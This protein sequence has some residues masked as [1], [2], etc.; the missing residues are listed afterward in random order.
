MSVLKNKTKKNFRKIKKAKHLTYK[1]F[2]KLRKHKKRFRTTYKHG[3]KKR[4]NATIKLH[5][6]AE[7]LNEIVNRVRRKIL[8][9]MEEKIGGNNAN[10]HCTIKEWFD[11]LNFN[12]GKKK[13]N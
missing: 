6:N 1:N 8:K 13:L 3:G 2:K 11:A 9:K 7:Q 12:T 4:L 5:R 10:T